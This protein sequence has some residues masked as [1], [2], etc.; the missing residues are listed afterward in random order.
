MWAKNDAG[1]S[2]GVTE[3]R[4]QRAWQV[5]CSLSWWWAK[6]SPWRKSFSGVLPLKHH[7]VTKFGAGARIQ[8]GVYWLALKGITQGTL[9]HRPLILLKAEGMPHFPFLIFKFIFCHPHVVLDGF[10]TI[11]PKSSWRRPWCLRFWSR[12]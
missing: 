5:G 8:E 12:Q 3:N 4:E 10:V 9:S 2:S 6:E 7:L 1:G 11:S